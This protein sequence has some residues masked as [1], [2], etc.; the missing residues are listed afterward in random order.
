MKI[1][2]CR[3]TVYIIRAHESTHTLI[4]R[5][6]MVNPIIF[7]TGF[8]EVAGYLL[9]YNRNQMLSQWQYYTESK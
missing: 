1:Y 9:R 8:M 5:I 6:S 4:N 2:L 3:V 7:V